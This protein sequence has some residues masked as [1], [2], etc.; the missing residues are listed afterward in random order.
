M[1]AAGLA[2]ID[3]CIIAVILALLLLYFMLRTAGNNSPTFWPIGNS[4]RDLFYGAGDV[5]AGWAGD[6]WGIVDAA[7]GYVITEAIKSSEA[8]GYDYIT[9]VKFLVTTMW[10]YGSQNI[11]FMFGSLVHPLVDPAFADLFPAVAALQ[12]WGATV[13]Y[14][15]SHLPSVV[16]F[17]PSYVESQIIAIT[18]LVIQHVQPNQIADELFIATLPGI[19]AAKQAEIDILWKAVT[20]L[21]TA[22]AAIPTVAQFNPTSALARIAALEADLATFK[23]V[24]LGRVTA[25][26]GEVTKLEEWATSAGLQLAALAGLTALTVLTVEQVANLVKLGVNPC[27]CFLPDGELAFLIPL[28]MANTWNSI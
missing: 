12:T 4:I 6:L 10:N 15:L 24:A 13:D 5:V 27:M 3:I 11:L 20:G 21:Q 1:P 19:F 18:N 28:T 23:S 14:R 7:S 8:V 26:E 25:L 9:A 16:P 2:L 17:D 22:V